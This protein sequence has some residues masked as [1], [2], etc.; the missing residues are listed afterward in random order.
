MDMG[1][2]Q[3]SNI[4]AASATYAYAAAAGAMPATG[5]AG[6]MSSAQIDKTSKDFESMFISQMLEPM[7]GDSEGDEAFGSAESSDVYKG[8]LMDQ[9]GKLM[10]QSGGIGVADYVKKEL[11]KL[12]EHGGSL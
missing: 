9:Y 5:Q 6:A 1:S 7:F 11:L 12:Q 2:I 10:T 3:N 8:L 4:S